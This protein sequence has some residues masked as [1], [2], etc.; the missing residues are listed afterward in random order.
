M[1]SM[2][3]MIAQELAVRARDHESERFLFAAGAHEVQ[4]M[5]EVAVRYRDEA[6]SALAIVA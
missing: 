1:R 2:R 4:K 3:P 6:L 5:S